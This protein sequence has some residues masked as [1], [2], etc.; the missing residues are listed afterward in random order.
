MENR[1]QMTF[2]IIDTA[3]HIARIKPD[4]ENDLLLKTA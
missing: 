1:T 2:P 3:H 4:E